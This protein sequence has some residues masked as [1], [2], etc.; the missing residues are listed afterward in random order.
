[1]GSRGYNFWED[2]TYYKEGVYIW[3]VGGILL[4]KRGCTF[5]KE[6]VYFLMSRCFAKRGYKPGK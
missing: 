4:G 6:G 1:L 5:E 2:D 3:E